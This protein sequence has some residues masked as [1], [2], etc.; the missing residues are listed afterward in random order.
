MKY[1]DFVRHNAENNQ[2]DFL[3]RADKTPN[4]YGA[5]EVGVKPESPEYGLQSILKGISEGS[6]KA[7]FVMADNIAL[8]P[9]IAEVLPLVQ[10]LIVHSAVRNETTNYADV[11]FSCAT[12][13]EKNGTFTNEEGRVQRIRPA[14]ATLEADR[15]LDG[16]AMSRLD[17]FGAH[18]D[19]W[20]KMSKRDA[21]PSWRILAAIGT[22]LGARMRFVS[23][24]DVFKE[25]SEKIQSFKGL[26]YQKIGSQGAVL[27]REPV[28]KQKTVKPLEHS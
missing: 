7:L 13:A 27:N 9:E 23:S 3:I 11:V 5:N 21:R 2:D 18:N 16:F 17:K 26:S 4:S 10:L 20:T 25:I 6:I 28:Q 12:Y 1:I 22:A 19:R 24:E 8:V 15:A 14:V